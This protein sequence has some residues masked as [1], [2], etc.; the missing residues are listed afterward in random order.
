MTDVEKKDGSQSIIQDVKSG[1]SS[2]SVDSAAEKRLLWKCDL[3][4]LPILML[5][6]L[7]AFLD[8]I[9]ASHSL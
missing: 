2:V 6:Y 1:E 8:R 5:L 4:V 9:N 3:H 7:L